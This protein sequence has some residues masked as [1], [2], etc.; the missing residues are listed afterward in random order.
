MKSRG[1]EERWMMWLQGN[2]MQS[3]KRDVNIYTKYIYIYTFLTQMP[4]IAIFKR[5]HLFQTV[6]LGIRVCFQLNT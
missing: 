1:K 4:R 2:L 5:S 3:I 6:T